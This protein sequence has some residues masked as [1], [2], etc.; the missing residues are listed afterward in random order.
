MISILL[1]PYRWSLFVPLRHFPIDCRIATALKI[2]PF[3]VF[4]F[5]SVFAACA[6]VSYRVRDAR[7]PDGV[8]LDVHLEELRGWHAGLLRAL[9]PRGH[10]EESG[11]SYGQHLDAHDEGER[12]P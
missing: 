10:V 7:L 1:R 12:A 9:A 2:S 4:V 5:D 6:G 3:F 8:H 11:A